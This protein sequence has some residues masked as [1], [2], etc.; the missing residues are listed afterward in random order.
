MLKFGVTQNRKEKDYR[1]TDRKGNRREER[2]LADLIQ[3]YWTY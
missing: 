3:D 2:T 1:W